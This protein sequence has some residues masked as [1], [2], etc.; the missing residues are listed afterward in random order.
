LA[1]EAEVAAGALH[2]GGI[3]IA[4]G[5]FA[6]TPFLDFGLYGVQWQ[7][8]DRFEQR[9]VNGFVT[10]CSDDCRGLVG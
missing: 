4:D 6:G 10:G 7:F 8:G 1:G 9:L 2:L 3:S 5:V